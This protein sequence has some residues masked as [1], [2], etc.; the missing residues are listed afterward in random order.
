MEEGKVS[1]GVVFQELCS[2]FINK[3][4]RSGQARKFA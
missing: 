3:L 2:S 1:D 4:K